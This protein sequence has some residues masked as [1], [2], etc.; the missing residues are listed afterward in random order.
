MKKLILLCPLLFSFE[1]ARTSREATNSISS[2]EGCNFSEVFR[3]EGWSIPG[4]KDAKRSLHGE[5][6]NI[7]G[8]FVTVLI[9]PDE[10]S[11]TITDMSCSREHE[12]RLELVE[13]AIQIQKLWEFDFNGK[14][15]GYRVLY[16]WEAVEN[17]RRYSV[18]AT[19]DIVFYDLD[20]SGK[21]TLRK[22]FLPISSIIVPEWAKKS[23][24][25]DQK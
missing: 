9:P 18:G 25:A 13:R 15:F 1:T 5:F 19:S 4:L 21:F 12:G 24:E 20:G 16:N 17:G 23:R 22:S 2:P 3:K 10:N 6:K 7:P 8:V 11:F 14:V